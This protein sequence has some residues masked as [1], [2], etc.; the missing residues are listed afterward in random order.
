[1]FTGHL[2]G[3][4]PRLYVRDKLKVSALRKDILKGP[5]HDFVN[6]GHCE[7]LG[8]FCKGPKDGKQNYIPDMIQMVLYPRIIEAV[9]G[10]ANFSNDLIHNVDGNIL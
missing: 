2:A 10:L 9:N 4:H 8:C 3:P 5:S 1:M 6:T 7:K